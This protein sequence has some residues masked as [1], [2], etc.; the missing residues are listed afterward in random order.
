MHAGQTHISISTTH[1]RVDKVQSLLNRVA[2]FLN[3]LKQ[4]A[5]HLTSEQRWYRILSKAVEKYL[6]GRQLIPPIY[7]PT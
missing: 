5:E 3:E 2:T 7:V 1:G 4:I 6:N